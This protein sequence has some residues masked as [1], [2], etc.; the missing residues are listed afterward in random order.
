MTQ[1]ELTWGSYDLLLMM[2][3]LIRVEVISPDFIIT[4]INLMYSKTKGGSTFVDF[5]V[6][7]K[8]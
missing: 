4:L 1:K 5:S 8:L 6:F 7:A 2:D 3:C